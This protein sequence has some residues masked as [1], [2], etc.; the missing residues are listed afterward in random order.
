MSKYIVSTLTAPVKFID[1]VDVSGGKKIRKSVLVKGGAGIANGA[2][3]HP[4]TR[5]GVMTEVSDADAK[6]LS[7][8]SHFK[9]QQEAG[10]V[11]IVNI[12]RD[13]DTVA[14][15]MSTDDGSRPRN[16]E[17]AKKL[18]KKF[19]ETDPQVVTNKPK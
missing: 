19:D 11:K 7:E 4:V 10:F 9:R 16:S 1:W 3:G 6:F 2:L 8:H 15:S 12:A 17:D 18:G 5:K 14:Q 13:P